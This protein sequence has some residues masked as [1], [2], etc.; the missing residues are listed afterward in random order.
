MLDGNLECCPSLGDVDVCGVCNGDGS[1]CGASYWIWFVLT[2]GPNATADVRAA[3]SLLQDSLEADGLNGYFAAAGHVDWIWDDVETGDER[4]QFAVRLNYQLVC[5]S[6]AIFACACFC[7]HTCRFAA[8]LATPWPCLVLKCVR[9]AL[10]D[11]CRHATAFGPMSQENVLR[12]VCRQWSALP[13]SQA[14]TPRWLRRLA[15]QPYRLSGPYPLRSPTS[16]KR[17]NPQ[18]TSVVM[19]FAHQAKHAS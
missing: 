13:Q 12:L 8:W 7:Q 14:S 11:C 3:V 4:D 19:A 16:F 18:A 17:H 15:S 10:R 5:T 9:L 2:P 6:Y 1:A